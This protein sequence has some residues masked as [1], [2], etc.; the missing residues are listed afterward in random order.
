MTGAVLDVMR[1]V[2]DAHEVAEAV[3]DDVALAIRLGALPASG[4][5]HV[6]ARGVVV[7]VSCVEFQLVEGPES[8]WDPAVVRDDLIHLV[9]LHGGQVGKVVVRAAA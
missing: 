2:E 4:T 5:Y 9:E 3:S 7:D 6:Q 1:E 8:S